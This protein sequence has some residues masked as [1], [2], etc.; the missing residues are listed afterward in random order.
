MERKYGLTSHDFLDKFDNGLLDDDQD[1]FVWWSLIHG[2]EAIRERKN[3]IKRML[4][5]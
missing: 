2:L 1:Y 5:A 4:T 3:K